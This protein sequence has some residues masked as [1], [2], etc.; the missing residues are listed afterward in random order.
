MAD[1]SGRFRAK[2][3]YD[4]LNDS[5]RAKFQVLFER[6]AE[7]GIIR[8]YEHFRGEEGH[9]SCFKRGQHRLACFRDGGDVMLVHGFRKKSDKD[10]RLKR[11]IETA[12]RIRVEYMNRTPGSG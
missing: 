12:E 8:N 1:A 5:E 11:H 6:M 10:K 4:S 9:I 3:Y 2:D 7:I